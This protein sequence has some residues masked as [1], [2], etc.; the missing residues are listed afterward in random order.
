MRL[1]RADTRRF[2]SPEFGW[3][4]MSVDHLSKNKI[5]VRIRR[6]SIYIRSFVTVGGS[7]RCESK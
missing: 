3:D 5:F 6:L 2:A 1:K 4:G 7:Q